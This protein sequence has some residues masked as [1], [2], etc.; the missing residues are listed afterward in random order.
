M[1]GI[2]VALLAGV[3]AVPVDDG[4]VVEIGRPATI[5]I[6]R[7]DAELGLHGPSRWS[8]RTTTF[9]GIDRVGSE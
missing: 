2:D 3:F 5:E 8:R 6:H 7:G 1:N 4:T 9:D